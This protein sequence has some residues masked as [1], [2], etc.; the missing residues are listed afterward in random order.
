MSALQNQERASLDAFSGS[1]MTFGLNLGLIERIMVSELR[2]NYEKFLF[3]GKPSDL[4]SNR[5]L[6]NKL[7][8]ELCIQF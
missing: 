4:S 5:L 8:L 3:R 1:R 6:Q 7:T 2:V